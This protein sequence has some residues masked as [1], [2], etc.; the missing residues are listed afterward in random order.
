MLGEPENQFSLTRAALSTSGRAKSDFLLSVKYGPAANGVVR[1][2]ASADG[3]FRL[4]ISVNICCR[5][6]NIV[7]FHQVFGDDKFFPSRIVSDR[8]VSSDY[9]LETES[10]IGFDASCTAE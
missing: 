2:P 5:E 6:A 4:S 9:H 8:L 3:N 10:A 1:V 7:Q